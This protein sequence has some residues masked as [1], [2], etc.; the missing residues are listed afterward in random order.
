[1]NRPVAVASVLFALAGVPSATAARSAPF[2]GVW[3]RCESHEGTAYCSSYVLVQ[4]GHN[5]CGTWTYTASRSGYVGQLEATVISAT[6]L[7]KDRVCGS[8]GSETRTECSEEGTPQVAWEP[9]RGT[10]HRIGD[11]LDENEAAREPYFQRVPFKRGQRDE[12]RAQPWVT[13]CLARPAR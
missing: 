3:E 5:V 4:E 9:A 1:M 10:L 2:E 13:S 6:A 12:L 7:K 11:G 8:P